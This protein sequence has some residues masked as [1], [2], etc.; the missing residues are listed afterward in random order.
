MATSGTVTAFSA[1]RS[2]ILRAA[3]LNV[4][5][6]ST[7]VAMTA[8]KTSD[9][10]DVLNGIIAEWSVT[11]I[12]VWTTKEGILFPVSERGVYT[13]GH[14]TA[15][16]NDHCCDASD[17]VK[18]TLAT[19]AATGATTITVDDDEGI[20]DG[21]Q[22][23]IFLD[24]GDF[25]W[26]TVDGTPA[27]NVVTLDDALTG[28]AAADQQVYAY[29]ANISKP[30]R[31][32]DARRVAISDGRRIPFPKMYARRDFMELPDAITPGMPYAPWYNRQMDAGYLNLIPP[33]AN[34]LEDLIGFTWHRGIEDF[35]AAA[36]Q[37]DLPKEWIRCLTW[38]LSKELLARYPVS[39]Q[40]EQNILKN[41]ADSLAVMSGVDREEES[42]MFQPDMSAYAGN[43][44]S[45]GYGR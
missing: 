30:I 19:A 2:S 38:N 12:K 31:I 32:I 37:P 24:D 7:G 4:S 41:A 16:Q 10:S 36:D 43:P 18:T 25:F 15:A 26:T 14:A 6:V 20:E 22:I 44:W 45:G 23:G 1:T 21:N 35:T 9:F 27:S 5:A 42:V 3:A 13:I 17:M 8:E 29:G 28:A 39:S 33:P 40:R 11:G 34:P